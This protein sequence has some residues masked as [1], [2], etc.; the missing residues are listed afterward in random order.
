MLIL[1]TSIDSKEKAK[2]LAEKL[3]KK[4]LAACV[5]ISKIQSLY[6]WESK[7]ENTKEYVLNCK[8]SAKNRK[9]VM[10]FITKNHPYDLPEIIIIKPKYVN[11][12]YK[13]WVKNGDVI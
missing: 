11:K 13:M 6:I 8:I 10:K 12:K 5:Q 3:L 1:Q 2:F 9:K 4:E 7:F